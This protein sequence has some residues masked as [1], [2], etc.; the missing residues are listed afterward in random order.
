MRRPLQLCLSALIVT[1]SMVAAL[2]AF[3]DF[4]DFMAEQKRRKSVVTATQNAALDS[5][6]H[7]TQVKLHRLD[8]ADAGTTA[9]AMVL[10]GGVE[11][12]PAMVW[13][14]DAVPVVGLAGKYAGRHALIAMGDAPE[15]ADRKIALGSAVGTCNNVAFM[16][17]A[18]LPVGLTIG[19]ACAVAYHHAFPV[20]RQEV[21]V[22]VM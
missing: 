22:K 1:F 3:A 16:L 10:K 19:V 11:G 9:L 4:D 17:G 13:A 5:P 15:I 8:Y 6:R 12:N 7:G 2:P 21:L 18:T 14:G 20:P